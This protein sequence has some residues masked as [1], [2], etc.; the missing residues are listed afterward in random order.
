MARAKRKSAKRRSSVLQVSTTATASPVGLP[1][2]AFLLFGGLCLL[3][4]GW[5]IWLLIGWM[6]GL[7]FTENPRF[8]LRR[9]EAR[10]DGKI[11]EELL[12]EWT[13]LEPGTN[14]YEI[15]LP[16]L[17]NRLESHAIVHR[18]L[19]RRKLPDGIEVAVNERVPI[20]RMGRVEGRLNWLLDREGV[21]IQKSFTSKHLPFLVGIRSDV[22]LGDSVDEDRA[23]YALACIE[24]L[25]ELPAKMR[26]LL[27]VRAISIGHPDYLDVR[28]HDGFQILL[29]L[30][31]DYQEMWERASRSIYGIQQN[32]LS[33]RKINLTPSG[34][35]VIVGP[36]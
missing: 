27:Q 13:K 28:T 5:G 12:K 29:P 24:D 30:T 7:L 8:E 14:L 1:A 36:K 20:A 10:T 18:A 34:R 6:N 9:I 33:D 16:G 22:T 26:E 31:D 25:R 15:H 23:E 17:K 35:N 21:V 4:V 11:S 19:V 3:V 32:R 2:G